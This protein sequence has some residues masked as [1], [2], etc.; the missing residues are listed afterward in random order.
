M[1][2]ILDKAQAKEAQKVIDNN[3]RIAAEANRQAELERMRQI[4]QAKAIAQAQYEQGLSAQAVRDAQAPYMIGDPK[5]N[6][7]PTVGL[8]G[9]VM[10]PIDARRAADTNYA[11]QMQ[12]IQ[13]LYQ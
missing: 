13:S 5:N 9:M 2:S 7:K 10:G 12:A 11:Q 3:A 4:E 1:G 6:G 8:A